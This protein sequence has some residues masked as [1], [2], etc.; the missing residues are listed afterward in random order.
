MLHK[1]AQQMSQLA[2]VANC[3]WWKDTTTPLPTTTRHMGVLWHLLFYW[4]QFG[5]NSN[6]DGE[7]EGSVCQI[8]WQ[9]VKKHDVYTT[10]LRS[11]S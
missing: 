9:Y 1:V 8:K 6:N 2:H 7:G 5:H 4:H 10:L 3:G 11:L